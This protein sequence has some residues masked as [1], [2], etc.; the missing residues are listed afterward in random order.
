MQESG[1][2]LIRLKN[3]GVKYE[4]REGRWSFSQYWALKDISF[5]ISV[6]ESVGIVGRNGSGKSTLLRLLT[7]IYKADK[8]KFEKCR[9]Y[10]ASLIALN[11]G[12]TA[13][14]TGR[15]NVVLSALLLGLSQQE[16][17]GIVEDV[18]EFCGL[19]DFFDR[20]VI[21]YSTGMK[22]KLGFSIAQYANPDLILLDE[23]LGVGDKDFKLK[24]TKIIKEK[25][26]NKRN[27]VVLVSHGS[28]TLKELCTK[29]IW[30]EDG[31]VFMQGDPEQVTDAYENSKL[32]T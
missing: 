24:S 16:A 17:E 10:T 23:T 27:T 14:L 21:T 22:A 9:D 2:D 20:P 30:I 7:G 31:C 28:G 3:I 4:R 6:G 15:E 25:I 11:V 5:N 29:V 8:G 13:H 32:T 26:L 1:Q 12:F 19:G 18:K